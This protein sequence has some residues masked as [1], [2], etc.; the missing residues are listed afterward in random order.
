MQVIDV[1]TGSAEIQVVTGTPGEPAPSVPDNAFKLWEQTVPANEPELTNWPEPEDVRNFVNTGF[2][3]GTISRDTIFLVAPLLAGGARIEPL[4]EDEFE[5]SE[6]GVFSFNQTR[7]VL[8]AAAASN[9]D[10]DDVRF[11]EPAA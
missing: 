1:D 3:G 11:F 8:Q 10:D 7:I 4:S 6:L 9:G 5:I 2:D